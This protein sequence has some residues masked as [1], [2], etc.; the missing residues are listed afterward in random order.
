MTDST[1]PDPRLL[2]F[3]AGRRWGVLTTIKRDG[4]PQLSNVGYAWDDGLVRVSVTADRAKTRNLQ[5]DPRVTLHV[6]SEDFWS[7][8]AVEGTAELTPVAQEPHDATVEEL[9]AYYR[10]ISGEH[11]DW[12]EYRAAM[13]ADRRLVVRFRPEHAYGQLR[14]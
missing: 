7:W 9:V 14:G 4:R 11:E 6:S 1:G 12:D 3:V 8:V 2:Q 5:R 10:G 13:V